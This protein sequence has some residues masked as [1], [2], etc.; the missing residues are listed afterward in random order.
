MNDSLNRTAFPLIE[1]R[2]LHNSIHLIHLDIIVSEI[3]GKALYRI[4]FLSKMRLTSFPFQ[5]GAVSIM[6]LIG[7]VSKTKL[8]NAAPKKW[9]LF[10]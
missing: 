9:V 8:I 2:Q 6:Q 7:S 10:L 1:V 5:K 3:S 4:R